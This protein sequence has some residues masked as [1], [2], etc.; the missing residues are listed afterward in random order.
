M[1]RSYPPALATAARSLLAVISR[2]LAVFPAAAVLVA[3]RRILQGL[4][5]P[6]SPVLGP[7]LTGG[8][9]SVAAL[10][11]GLAAFLLGLACW[12]T[13]GMGLVVASTPHR[14]LA[15]A[16]EPRRG[17][18]LLLIGLLT[19]FGIAA[20]KATLWALL[21]LLTGPNTDLLV[22]GAS[23]TALFVVTYTALIV[24][25]LSLSAGLVALAIGARIPLG[26]GSL[27]SLS[28]RVFGQAL[29]MLL[30]SRLW[31]SLA[32]GLATLAVSLPLTLLLFTSLSVSMVATGTSR[33]ALEI[34]QALLGATLMLVAPLALR[35]GLTEVHPPSTADEDRTPPDRTPASAAA[36]PPQARGTAPVESGTGSAF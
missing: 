26:T 21:A 10:Q 29:S 2:P 34:V 23:M 8:P 5:D 9:W 12:L 18:L 22:P 31:P 35:D 33:V 19:N 7:L 32:L 25:C 30:G 11:T 17:L 14:G 4:A 27:S 1:L 20:P 13:L 28:L 3:S 36:L 16:L 15:Q 24:V 6:D